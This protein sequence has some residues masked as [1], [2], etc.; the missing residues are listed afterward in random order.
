VRTDSYEGLLDSHAT[1]IMRLLSPLNA[2]VS[3]GD[4]EK[5]S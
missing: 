3:H 1:A 4:S 5:R 2:E